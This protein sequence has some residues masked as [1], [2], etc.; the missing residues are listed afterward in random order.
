MPRKTK[1]Q[2]ER[3]IADEL[4]KKHCVRVQVPG[5]PLLWLTS[6]GTASFSPDEA[7]DFGS[8]EAAE[9]RIESLQGPHAGSSYRYATTRKPAA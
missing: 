9:R 1:A 6:K 2:I 7:H 4:A 5:G 3:E 8:R